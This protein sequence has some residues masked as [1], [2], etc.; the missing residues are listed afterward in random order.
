MPQ[1]GSSSFLANASNRKRA[2]AKVREGLLD[3]PG[4]PRRGGPP[5]PTVPA[6][7]R[8]SPQERAV[9]QSRPQSAGPQGAGP[10]AT[11][12]TLAPT[13]EERPV[14][15]LGLDDE[16]R[17]ELMAQITPFLTKMK[18]QKRAKLHRKIGR[19]RKFFG[20]GV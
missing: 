8:T 16:T 7:N 11:P 6:Q 14:N 15:A 20:G 4:I 18:M 3:R 10:Q 9:Q 12:P 17:Q 19:S 5:P 13:R 1:V 2:L